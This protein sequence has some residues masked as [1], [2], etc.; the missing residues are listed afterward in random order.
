MLLK[1]LILIF[2][3]PLHNGRQ[4]SLN[5]A[6]QRQRLIFRLFK[7]VT[8]RHFGKHQ[9]PST[10]PILGGQLSTMMPSPGDAIPSLGMLSSSLI[11]IILDE[12]EVPR[13]LETVSEGDRSLWVIW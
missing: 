8:E 7:R 6:E 3:L 12:S 4:D 11:E 9:M 1:T 13:L 2:P 5:E 10:L